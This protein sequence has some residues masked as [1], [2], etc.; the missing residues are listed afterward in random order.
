[1]RVLY[2]TDLLS[3]GGTEKHMSLLAQ[4]LRQYGYEPTFIV[5]NDKG[6]WGD[7]LRAQQI[8]IIRFPLRPGFRLRPRPLLTLLPL[9]FLIQRQRA[10]VVIGAKYYPSLVACL[11]AHL[12]KVPVKIAYHVG[13]AEK[14]N[15][16][17]SQIQW[18]VRLSQ[19]VTT[20]FV[21]NSQA[22]AD[23]IQ[24]EDGIRP[25]RI[26]VIYQGVDIP[27]RPAGDLS[28]FRERLNT[29]GDNVI[30]GLLANLSSIK[31]PLMLVRAAALVV[32]QDP[33]VTFVLAGEEL[34][35]GYKERLD[36]E[37]HRLA[38]EPHFRVLD[39]LSDP[40]SL[41]EILDIGILCS[42][43]EGFSNS[44]LEYMSFGKPVIATRVGG[45]LEAIVDGETGY[46]VENND[47]E[48]LAQHIQLLV[49]DPAKRT[50]MGRRGL[51]RVQREFTWDRTYK[52]FDGLLHS[53]LASQGHATS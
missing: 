14:A 26:K 51:E 11:A 47:V 50:E 17:L 21:T 22:I 3:K 15:R 39:S 37:I 19:K 6:Y 5:G 45:N 43:S 16:P 12:A 49:N 30:I 31:N 34:E 53:L 10:D 52:Q 41:L 27:T 23:S 8:R 20:R 40:S 42:S 24:R 2:I 13:L 4:G 32:P 36:K 1:M 7:Y 46:L 9:V 48:A 29:A 28:S 38:L 18:M 33:Q 44:I 35:R 25:E